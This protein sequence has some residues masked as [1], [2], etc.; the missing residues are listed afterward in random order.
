MDY[1][2]VEQGLANRGLLARF[3]FLDTEVTQG[4]SHVPVFTHH[5]PAVMLHST[6]HMGVPAVSPHGPQSLQCLPCRP[7]Q[8]KF[9]SC[10]ES[11]GHL[12]LFPGYCLVT[13]TGTVCCELTAHGSGGQSMLQP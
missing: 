4:H 8:R 9:S 12:V 3:L 1:E 6:V 5:L 2:I 13:W 11:T 10:C 7:G